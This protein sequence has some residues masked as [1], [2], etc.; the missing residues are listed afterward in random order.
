MA[1]SA[2]RKRLTFPYKECR[3]T[4]RICHWTLTP[5]LGCQSNAP[6]TATRPGH[7]CHK[8]SRVI[9]AVIPA[10]S[11]AG[12]ANTDTA[13]SRTSKAEGYSKKYHTSP[14]PFF[15]LFDFFQRASSPKCSRGGPAGPRVARGGNS[16]LK[17]NQ[18]Q[19]LVRRCPRGCNFPVMVSYDN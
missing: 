9:F 7:A 5:G 18:N 3:H 17:K 6:T 4:H 1:R 12:S 2:R 14:P 15:S 16:C 10:Q 8:A 19:M 13:P 11:V